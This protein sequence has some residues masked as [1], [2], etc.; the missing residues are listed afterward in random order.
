MLMD[1][2]G[3]PV[4]R[5]DLKAKKTPNSMDLEILQSTSISHLG[6]PK[7]PRNVVS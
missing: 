3:K 2:R 6:I 4:L 5:E 7:T 1:V